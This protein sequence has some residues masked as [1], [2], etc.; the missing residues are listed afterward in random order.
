[1]SPGDWATAA[2]AAGA[3][4]AVI[5]ALFGRQIRAWL[6]PPRL[7]LRVENEAGV[8]AGDTS[9]YHLRVS[10]PRRWSP[11]TAVRVFLLKIEMDGLA[12]PWVD[13]VPL[14]W[15]FEKP[16]GEY[17]DVGFAR[18][19]DLCAVDDCKL[20]LQPAIE[21]GLPDDLESFHRPVRMT[22]TLQARGLEADSAELRLLLD[23]D[24]AGT[25]SL[26]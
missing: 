3:F 17:L 15:R 6:T 1:M 25:L 16:G 24:G 5:V 10:N 13:E 2:G 26:G 22:L 19:C 12:A 9:W 23:W 20:T 18:D 7:D 4:A 8:R 14:R 21:W 11:V